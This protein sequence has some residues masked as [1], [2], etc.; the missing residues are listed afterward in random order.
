MVLEKEKSEKKGEILQEKPIHQEEV[1]P[2]VPTTPFPEKLKAQTRDSNFV[3]FLEIF[4]KL[5]LNIHFLEVISHKPNYAKFV[6]EL[7]INKK[8]L[9]EYAMVALT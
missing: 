4:K 3:K 8:R 9:E 1:K 7:V 6:K 2:Y 5:E